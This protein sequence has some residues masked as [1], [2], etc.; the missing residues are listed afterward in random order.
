MKYLY[1]CVLLAVVAIVSAQAPPE[2]T[3]QAAIYDGADE[4][5]CNC[6]AYDPDC[7]T[8]SFVRGCD[9]IEGSVYFCDDVGVCNYVVR[10]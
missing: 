5:D 4:C 1:F 9:D 3:C 7:D 2:W 10:E 8:I 6:G